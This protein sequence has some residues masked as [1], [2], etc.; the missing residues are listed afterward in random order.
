MADDD[1]QGA[2]NLF[3]FDYNEDLGTFYFSGSIS[4]GLPVTLQV[5]VLAVAENGV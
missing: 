2:L 5:R 3:D 1:E 4:V